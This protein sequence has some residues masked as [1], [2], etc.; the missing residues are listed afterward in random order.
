[1]GYDV[2]GSGDQNG[3]IS[4]QDW[5]LKGTVSGNNVKLITSCLLIDFIQDHASIV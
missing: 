1:M 4:V 2:T 3:P 5:P